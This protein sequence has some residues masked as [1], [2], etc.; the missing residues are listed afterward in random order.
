MGVFFLFPSFMPSPP[1]E[2]QVGDLQ[3]RVETA[4]WRKGACFLARRVAAGD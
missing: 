2:A 3:R 4:S 1:I